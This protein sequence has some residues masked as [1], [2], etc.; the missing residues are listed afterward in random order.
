MKTDISLLLA[1]SKIISANLDS[2]A[3]IT[4][5]LQLLDQ[6][7]GLSKAR[8]LLPNQDNILE[9]KFAYGHTEKEILRGKYSLGEGVTGK[10]MESGQIA[11][12]PDIRQEPR[13]LNKINESI[14]FTDDTIAY[15]AVPILKENVP[16]GVLAVYRSQPDVNTLQEDLGVLQVI[17]AMIQMVLEIDRLLSKKTISLIL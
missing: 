17:A 7:N 9:I 12:I 14:T 6:V 1:A 16:K 3:A 8:V 10:V 2:E 5:L 15:I 11:L 4:A 13:Y